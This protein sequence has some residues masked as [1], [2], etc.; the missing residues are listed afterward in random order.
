M[1]LRGGGAR[2]MAAFDRD[3]EAAAQRRLL[4]NVARQVRDTEG[5]VTR[6]PI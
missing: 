6:Q 4:G 5:D 1:R 3:C 2:A